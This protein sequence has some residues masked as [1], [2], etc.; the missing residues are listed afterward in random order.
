MSLVKRNAYLYLYLLDI[1][2]QFDNFTFFFFNYDTII[3]K[4]VE[5]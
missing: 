3:F 1:L 4:E 5:K 2:I